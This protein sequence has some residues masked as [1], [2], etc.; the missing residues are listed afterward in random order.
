VRYGYSRAK[1]RFDDVYQAAHDWAFTV[2][3]DQGYGIC[4]SA[5]YIT[6]SMPV[7]SL[8]HATAL[9]AGAAVHSWQRHEHQSLVDVSLRV[10][11]RDAWARGARHVPP[12]AGEVALF[13]LREQQYPTVGRET[14]KPLLTAG[15]S[16]P[17]APC[18][19]CLRAINGELGA[20]G[21]GKSEHESNTATFVWRRP[22]VVILERRSLSLPWVESRA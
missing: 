11:R 18:F 22:T 13:R 20:S 6:I 1:G 12:P 15:D 3:L 7:T 16:C 4:L 5:S 17:T 14:P 9:Y 21:I 19:S 2:C 10:S 8:L